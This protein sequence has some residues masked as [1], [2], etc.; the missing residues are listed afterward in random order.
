M[1]IDNK[2][3]INNSDS[4]RFS[5]DFNEGTTIDTPPVKDSD[6]N[7]E[8]LCIANPNT[9][10]TSLTTNAEN[11][12]DAKY[13]VN[14]DVE[15]PMVVCPITIS[16]LIENSVENHNDISNQP[17]LQD[18]L[19]NI[20]NATEGS[21]EDQRRI[22]RDENTENKI[23][24]VPKR[25]LS[26]GMKTHSSSSIKV[27]NYTGLRCKTS[28]VFIMCCVI[29]CCLIPFTAYYVSQA[30]DSDVTDPEYSHEKNTSSIKV[31]IKISTYL[32]P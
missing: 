18:K 5:V 32:Y 12:A 9:C 19:L 4:C 26:P 27:I 30:R 3:S 2:E 29:G 15:I 28:L 20:D 8:M 17:V 16:G 24:S 14:T 10:D 21:P 23:T 7:L 25:P 1:L 6:M 11:S 13:G 22:S 31:C